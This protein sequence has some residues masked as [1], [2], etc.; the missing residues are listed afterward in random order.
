M[1]KKIVILGAGESGTGSAILAKKRGFRV[2]VSDNG[3]I[4]PKY[5]EMLEKAEIRFEEANHNEV[6]ILSA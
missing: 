1:K 6:E 5:K 3:Q 4:K 2:F